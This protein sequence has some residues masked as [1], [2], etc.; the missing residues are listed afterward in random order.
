MSSTTYGRGTHAR[1][2]WLASETV[3]KSRFSKQNL[4]TP[5]NTGTLLL[6]VW[7]FCTLGGLNRKRFQGKNKWKMYENIL[8]RKRDCHV[9]VIYN[10]AQRQ[11][12]SS[13]DRSFFL[14]IC[15]WSFHQRQVVKLIP[16]STKPKRSSTQ[17]K[18]CIVIDKTL[19]DKKT[20]MFFIIKIH[21][22]VWMIWK[23]WHIWQDYRIC[24]L[25]VLSIFTG[26]HITK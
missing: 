1:A 12:N 19:P 4:K 3:W 21:R 18:I 9:I 20:A 25:Q 17:Q 2:R 15:S 23:V 14:K 13:S 7:G 24:W 6:C 26:Y 10:S 8:V 16:P 5:K 11:N 22:S